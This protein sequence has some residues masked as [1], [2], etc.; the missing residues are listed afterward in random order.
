MSTGHAHADTHDM[1]TTKIIK[2]YLSHTSETR[3]PMESKLPINMC[4]Y[5]LFVQMVY[6]LS[7]F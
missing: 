7:R 6:E 4:I 3:Q 1:A 5:V 2:M